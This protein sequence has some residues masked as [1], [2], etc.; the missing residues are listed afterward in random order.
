MYIVIQFGFEEGTQQLNRFAASKYKLKNVFLRIDCDCFQINKCNGGS[1][2]L[3]TIS[4]LEHNWDTVFKYVNKHGKE[5]WNEIRKIFVDLINDAVAKKEHIQPI[6][7]K[8]M[9]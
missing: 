1:T 9:L 2:A 8:M 5:Q 7:S 3:C 4:I 6:K